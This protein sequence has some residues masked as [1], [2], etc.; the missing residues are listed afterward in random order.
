MC[1]SGGGSKAEMVHGQLHF[2][3]RVGQ[4]RGCLQ[5][6]VGIP[7]SSCPFGQF[8]SGPTAAGMVVAQGTG[9]SGL[10][11]IQKWGVLLA[12]TDHPDWEYHIHNF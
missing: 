7:P 4:G 8:V 12:Q 9:V 5:G 3:S 6:T 11:D 10:S 2:G 1:A